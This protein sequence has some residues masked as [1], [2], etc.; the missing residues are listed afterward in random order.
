MPL[1]SIRLPTSWTVST[2]YPHTHT[3]QKEYLRQYAN[4]NSVF[5]ENPVP[6]AHHYWFHI[7][8]YYTNIKI[9]KFSIRCQL[10]THCC[11]LYSLENSYHV[12]SL[13]SPYP[14]LW[15]SGRGEPVLLDGGPAVET[16]AAYTTQ[17]VLYMC[18]N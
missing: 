18:H 4:N 1:H 17:I 11:Y 2:V 10:S 6:T 7:P 15:I 8:K 12:E 13:E 3:L 14:H 5:L 9:V 16:T